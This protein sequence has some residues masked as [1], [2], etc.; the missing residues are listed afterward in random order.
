M[1]RADVNRIDLVCPMPVRFAELFDIILDAAR[2]RTETVE[3]W[4]PAY[5]DRGLGPFEFFSHMFN[6]LLSRCFRI[7]CEVVRE[8]SGFCY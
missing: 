3:D 6:N 1:M 7:K 8:Q 2:A 4:F 5:N